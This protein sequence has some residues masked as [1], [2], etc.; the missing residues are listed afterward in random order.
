MFRRAAVIWMGILVL[1]SRNGAV[2]D[3]LVAP[4][5]GDTLAR[6]ISTLVL[7]GLVLLVTLMAIRWTAP[8]NPQAA[9]AVGLLW[10]VLTLTFE[11]RAGRLLG[12]RGR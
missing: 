12:S 4:R 2:R 6:A 5:I 11:V 3:R 9:L 8:P 1:A 7:C 10:L